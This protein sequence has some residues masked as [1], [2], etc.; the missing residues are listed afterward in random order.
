MAIFFSHA[1]KTVGNLSAEFEQ[2]RT[3]LSGCLFVI[4]KI[5]AFIFIK[6]IKGNLRFTGVL[7]KPF[8]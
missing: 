3:F 4:R 7:N 8:N 6:I 5:L 2:K 1:M